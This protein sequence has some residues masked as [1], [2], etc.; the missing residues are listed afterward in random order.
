MVGLARKVLI[1]ND[2][3]PLSSSNHLLTRLERDI[4]DVHTQMGMLE[5]TFKNL[6][7]SWLAIILAHKIIKDE[8][9]EEG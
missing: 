3:N 5:L 9:E 7:G 1:M 2:I 6:Q 8:M 4:R